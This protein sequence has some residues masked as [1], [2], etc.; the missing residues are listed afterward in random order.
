MSGGGL[1]E[2]KRIQDAN[3]A[4]LSRISAALV[5]VIESTDDEHLR[6]TAEA[7]A[8]GKAKNAAN[9]PWTEKMRPHFRDYLR[10]DC[11]PYKRVG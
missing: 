5:P 6:A 11:R 2:L 4:E 8:E 3:Q 7:A 9:T 10:L 1:A